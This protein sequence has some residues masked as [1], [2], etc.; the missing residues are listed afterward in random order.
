ML[1]TL[2][3][4]EFVLYVAPWIV[5]AFVC[6]VAMIFYGARVDIA[7][8]QLT[9]KDKKISYLERKIHFLEGEKV[10]RTAN[11][12]YRSAGKEVKK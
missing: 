8:E 5:F 2:A 10:I 4:F 7:K 11:E 9:E 1:R 12:H 6:L 3:L